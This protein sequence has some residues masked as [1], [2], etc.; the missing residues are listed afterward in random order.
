MGLDSGNGT[1]T[2]R[3]NDVDYE[4]EY[5][6]VVPKPVAPAS[7]EA[8]DITVLE[9]LE[10][11]RL[12][13]GMYIGSTGPTGLHHLVWEVV[14]N[15]VDEA[16]AGFCT[17][18]DVTLLANGGCRVIDNGRGIPVEPIPGYPDK[19]AAEV[20]LTVLHAGG[21]F[22]GGE[23]QGLRWPAWRRRVGRERP[24]D[25]ARARDR[26]GRQPASNGVRRRRQD[27]KAHLRWSGHHP[28]TGRGRRSPSGRTPRSSRRRNSGPRPYSSACR[29]WPSSTGVSRSASKT[30]APGTKPRRPSLQRRDRRLRQA[31]QRLQGAALP[32]GGSFVQAEPDQEVEVALQWNTGYYESIHSFANGISTIEGGMHEEGFKKALTNV[33][34]NYA[35][36]R[37]LVKEKATTSRARTSARD[38][39]PSSRCG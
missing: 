7:Y 37:N 30:S 35:R 33:V 29:S 36:Q 14:D 8:E 10:P 19:T 2:E 31:S 34:N 3:P 21:K 28:G 13:P 15:A 25:T 11:V 32:Q 22:G 12:R 20:V 24:V 5:N 27:R 1:G 26:P 18:I 16:M 17:R 4:K 39:R 23:L 9:G 6:D 38:S